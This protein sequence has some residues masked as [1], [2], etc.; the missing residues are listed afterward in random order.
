MATVQLGDK[1]IGDIVKIEWNGASYEYIIV[2]KGKPSSLYDDSFNDGVILLMKSALWDAAWSYDYSNYNNSNIHIWLHNEMLSGYNKFIRDRTKTVK[3]PY[4]SSASPSIVSSGSEGLDVKLFLL[5]LPELG[6]DGIAH[7]LYDGSLFDYF[8]GANS[9]GA[10]ELRVAKDSTNTPVAWWTRSQ[11]QALTN[12]AYQVNTTGDAIN[13]SIWGTACSLRVAMV[14][15]SYLFVA[16]NILINNYIIIDGVDGD[17]GV[18]TAP[19]AKE[20]VVSRPESEA[21]VTVTETIN[22]TILRQY[23]ATSGAQQSFTVDEDTFRP[24][25]NGTYTLTITASDQY[26]AVTRTW[27]FTR[28][29]TQINISLKTPILSN[30]KPERIKLVVKRRIP[31]GVT[32]QTHV[33]NNA[34]D[35]EPTWE[36]ATESVL[37]GSIH[38]FSNGAKTATEWGVNVQIDIDRN[39]A[40]GDCYVTAITGNYD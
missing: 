18:K 11:Q 24:L 32:F 7:M 39:E 40:E 16:D 12:S 36:D 26:E 4:R 30:E 5:S 8:E 2:H 31:Q 29:E 6:F 3:I 27:T 10:D 13:M 25:A 1:N 17:L 14:L 28:D 9:N 19:F 15:P 37:K 38:N 23:T 22:G 21:A 33:C 35:D 20:Y 34:Y